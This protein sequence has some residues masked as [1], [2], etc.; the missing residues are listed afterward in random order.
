MKQ[1]RVR[2]TVAAK[3]DSIEQVSETLF[4]VSVKTKAKQGLANLRVR[5]LLAQYLNVPIKDV[6]LVRGSDTRSK[7]VVVHNSIT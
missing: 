5:E 1:F 3:T 7:M 2:V 4:K 6:L